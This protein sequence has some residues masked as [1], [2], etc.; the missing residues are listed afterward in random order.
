MTKFFAI[1]GALVLMTACT[2]TD[3]AATV[4][5]TADS[6]VVDTAATVTDSVVAQ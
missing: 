1:L 2:T 4:D 3:S 6:S 5:S